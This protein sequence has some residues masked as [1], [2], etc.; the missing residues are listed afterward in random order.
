MLSVDVFDVLPRNILTST[1]VSQATCMYARVHPST[2]ISSLHHAAC[3]SRTHSLIIHSYTKPRSMDTQDARINVS[4][5]LCTTPFQWHSG[6]NALVGRM[7]SA[8]TPFICQR[9]QSRYKHDGDKRSFH[10]ML[11]HA[12]FVCAQ[13]VDELHDTYAHHGHGHTFTCI[14][15]FL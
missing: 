8:C 15:T 12:R 5:F 3:S 11:Q 1:Q 7:L 2:H 10:D 4:H 13:Y 9:T 14:Y 6:T